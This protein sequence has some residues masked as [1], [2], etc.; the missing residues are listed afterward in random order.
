M[1]KTKKLTKYYGKHV[2]MIDIDLDVKEREIFGLIGP[3]GAGK[4][5]MIRTLMGYLKPSFGSGSIMGLDIVEDKKEILAHVGYMPSES[6]FYKDVKVKDII[7]LSLDL[8]NHDKT[9]VTEDL[10]KRFDVDINK[11]I[12]ELSLGNRKKVSLVCAFQ[13]EPKILFLDE[14]TSGLDP[15]MKHEFFNLIKERNKK[16]STIFFSSHVLSEIQSLCDRAAFIKEGILI[17]GPSFNK[18]EG[19][20]TK[21]V[22]LKTNKSFPPIPGMKDIQYRN[23]EIEFLFQGDIT[24]LIHHLSLNQID[25]ITIGEPNLEEIFM[26]YYGEAQLSLIHI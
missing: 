6:I 11:H 16:G 21:K 4:S 14:P 22:N 20:L 8:R 1:I 24:Q 10:I 18:I 23:H 19:M 3:N 26:H 7:Q 5:T 2:G 25:D 13:H 17:E 12:S 15:L 9:N